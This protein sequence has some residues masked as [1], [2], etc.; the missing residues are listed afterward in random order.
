MGTATGV[1]QRTTCCI[2]VAALSVAVAA[3]GL[4]TRN[5]ANEKIEYNVLQLT[6]YFPDK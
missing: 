5:A 2:P 3:F 4:L 1:Q 6:E